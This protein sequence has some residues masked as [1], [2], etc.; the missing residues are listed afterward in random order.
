MRE[1]EAFI[2]FGRYVQYYYLHM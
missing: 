1:Q 2:L